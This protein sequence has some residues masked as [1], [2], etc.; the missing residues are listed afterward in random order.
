MYETFLEWWMKSESR[1]KGPHDKPTKPLSLC[2]YGRSARRTTLT[3]NIVAFIKKR[4][5]RM[6]VASSMGHGVP[7]SFSG[8]QRRFR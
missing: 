3:R 5:Q 1:G 4:R 6:T 7:R 2:V 8:S